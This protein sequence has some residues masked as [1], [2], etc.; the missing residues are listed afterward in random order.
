MD[1]NDWSKAIMAW[2][3]YMDGLRDT[4]CHC[5]GKLFMIFELYDLNCVYETFFLKKVCDSCNQKASSKINYYGAK[6]PHEIAYCRK[7][8][9]S[10]SYAIKNKTKLFNALMYAGY[11]G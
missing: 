7:V 8:L 4:P 9:N 5:C 10:G 11:T 1:S 6:K 3:N 2:D